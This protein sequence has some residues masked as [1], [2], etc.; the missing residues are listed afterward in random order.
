MTHEKMPEALRLADWLNEGWWPSYVPQEAAEEL[1]RQHSEIERL[2]A[3]VEGLRKDA[4]RY[5]WLR[6]E[7]FFIREACQYGPAHPMISFSYDIWSEKPST[8]NSQGLDAAI[9]AA[10]KKG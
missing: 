5:R 2:R 1:R 3:E 8:H 10:R 6:K 4:E 9:D 7:R